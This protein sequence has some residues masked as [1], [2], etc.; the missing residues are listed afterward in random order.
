M[1]EFL[2]WKLFQ[3]YFSRSHELGIEVIKTS[4]DLTSRK[5]VV[6]E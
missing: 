2:I 6:A 4:E 3:D 5:A 1:D